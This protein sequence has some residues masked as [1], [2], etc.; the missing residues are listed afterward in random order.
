MEWSSEWFASMLDGA[1]RHPCAWPA[2]CE[3]TVEFDDEPF[4]FTHSPDEGSAVPGYSYK[5]EHPR[6]EPAD[7]TSPRSD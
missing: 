3:H 7:D 2:G 6:K 1:E 4:C 5:R